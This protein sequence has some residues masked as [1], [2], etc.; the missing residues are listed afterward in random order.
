MVYTVLTNNRILINNFLKSFQKFNNKFE[1][2]IITIDNK[3]AD[4]DLIKLDISQ[5]SDRIRILKLTDIE[6]YVI[7]TLNLKNY[8][9][10]VSV[11]PIQAKLIIPF[12]FK[13]VLKIN[14]FFMFDDD[15]LI[16]C[17]LDSL[18][19][20]QFNAAGTD[21]RSEDIAKQIHIQDQLN[22]C[23][24]LL[25]YPFKLKGRMQDFP[26]Y[27]VCAFI[28]TVYDDYGNYIYNFFQSEKI[29]N[30]I[31][32]NSR[33]FT[34]KQ[35]NQN[36]LYPFE[37]I[38]LNVYN[39]SHN[40]NFKIFGKE[41]VFHYWGNP[42]IYKDC[43]LALKSKIIHAHLKDK[44]QWYNFY[45][46]NKLPEINVCFVLD[47]NY[48]K[49]IGPCIASLFAHKNNYKI[50]IISTQ[51]LTGLEWLNCKGYIV[52]IDSLRKNF[53]F[54]DKTDRISE[55]AFLKLLIPEVLKDTDKVLYMDPDI[56]V[57]KNPIEFYQVNPEYIA[58]TE[59]YATDL[60]QAGDLGC[61]RYMLSGA[62]VMN[63]KKLREIQF[64]RKIFEIDQSKIYARHWQHEETLINYFFKD[65]L[66]F[67]PIEYHY[68][69][70]RKY[71]INGQIIDFSNRAHL[72]HIPGPDKSRMFN[73]VPNYAFIYYKKFLQNKKVIIFGSGNTLNKYFAIHKPE[74]D[75]IYISVN[76]AYEELKKHNI[77]SDFWFC[78]DY[79][80]ATKN[81]INNVKPNIKSFIGIPSDY[82]HNRYY[83]WQFVKE[84]C[85]QYNAESYLLNVG[86][87]NLPIDICSNA[88]GDGGR[89]IAFSAMQFALWCEPKEIYL[90]G[91]DCTQIR[92]DNSKSGINSNTV[93]NYW[94]QIKQF[95]NRNYPDTKIWSINPIG[96]KDIF[97]EKEFKPTISAKI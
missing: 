57:R 53:R 12:Y 19:F 20:D 73:L 52:N 66:T 36:I 54:K 95:A 33:N 35:T 5:L 38:C 96:L 28:I 59:T 6:D 93:I 61:K 67:V 68:A 64:T 10:F 30:Y 85:S 22:A 18:N 82:Q 17:N 13:Q 89:S 34:V 47:Q 31:S 44:T 48:V 94:K 70:N 71:R 76:Q 9:T 55:A 32:Q 62:M 60:N 23:N 83:S 65:K 24:E 88:L 41:I 74:K 91:F 86:N 56:V 97:P 79:S 25:T 50:H 1:N 45:F 3:T 63:L 46:E 69:G 92:F 72:L 11:C 90:V 78:Q 7:K 16:N 2:L 14:K 27:V 21:N 51:K 49:Y 15:I 40:K 39:V 29:Y 87:Y 81:Y 84:D 77:N 37:E 80:G 42:K 4:F 43:Q 75:I 58:G 8:K 26:R